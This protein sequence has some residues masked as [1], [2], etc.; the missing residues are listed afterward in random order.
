LLLDPHLDIAHEWR[1][2]QF[3]DQDR[4]KD[5]K[6]QAEVVGVS[7]EQMDVTVARAERFAIRA[8]ATSAPVLMR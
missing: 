1:S 5:N 4:R 2:E 8:A 3:D 6:A 7:E